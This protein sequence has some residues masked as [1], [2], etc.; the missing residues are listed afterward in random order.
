MKYK[1]AT[2]ERKNCFGDD[3]FIEEKSEMRP[4]FYYRSFSINNSISFPPK[5]M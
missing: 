2:E 5:L 1:C 3:K 4:R